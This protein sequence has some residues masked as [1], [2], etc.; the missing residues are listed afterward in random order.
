[1]N[2]ARTIVE[3]ILREFATNGVAMDGAST[4]THAWAL[5]VDADYQRL[6]E[7]HDDR[8]RR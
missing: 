2:A 3:G 5:V 7:W 4:A 6:Q 1:M 8:Y